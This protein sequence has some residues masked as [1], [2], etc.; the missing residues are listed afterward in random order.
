MRHG[1]NA[2]ILAPIFRSQ[3]GPLRAESAGSPCT[4]HGLVRC[5]AL[6]PAGSA[7]T[8][9]PKQLCFAAVND[10]CVPAEHILL[11]QRNRAS[12]SIDACRAT[13]QSGTNQTGQTQ[14]LRFVGGEGCK[15]FGGTE[16]FR[17]QGVT[18]RWRR[19]VLPVDRVGLVDALETS[20]DPARQHRPIGDGKGYARYG[21][22]V[23]PGQGA[24]PSRAPE[25]HT[26]GQSD[27]TGTL[28]SS[29]ASAA[30]GWSDR[31]RGARIRTS[32]PDACRG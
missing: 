4:V 16:R 3:L 18:L 20:R 10:G 31:W 27:R 11:L 13:G 29:A 8:V 5:L 23:L 32:E 19:C 30:C 12:T 28:A 1:A 14:N 17:R 21:S 24:V 15:G 6:K 25:P 7:Q 9:R 26:R 22:D 2:P